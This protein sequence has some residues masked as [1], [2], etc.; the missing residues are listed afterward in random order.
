MYEGMQLDINRSWAHFE[1]IQPGQTQKTLPLFDG[2][3]TDRRYLGSYTR[4]FFYLTVA[5][6]G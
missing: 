2:M 6:V 5:P 4:D 3:P 1:A